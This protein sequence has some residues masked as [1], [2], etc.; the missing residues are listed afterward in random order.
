LTIDRSMCRVSIVL[1]AHNAGETLLRAAGSCLA[2][3]FDDLE[4]VI[5]D[6]A[7]GDDTPWLISELC[8]GDDRV[9]GI[10]LEGHGGVAVAA[11]AGRRAARGEFVARMDADDFSHPERIGKQVAY[12]DGNPDVAGCGTGVKLVGAPAADPGRGFGAHVRWLNSL[13]APGRM[14]AER[15]V[16]S[17]IANPSSMVRAES[18]D[19]VGGHRDTDWA[20]DYDLWLRMFDKGLGLANVGEVLLDW[21]DSPG[22]LTRS[23]DRYSAANFSRAKAHY[24][25][26]LPQVASAGV[27]IAGAGPIG[28]RLARDLIAEGVRVH[29]FYEVNPRRVGQRIGDVPVEGYASLDLRDS[30]LLGSVGLPGARGQIR[31]LARA[32]GFREGCDFFPVA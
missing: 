14:A 4:L 8:R 17:P 5:V 19:A 28:K 11:E 1:P 25:A 10:Q 20:E 29:R 32:A 26:K 15:F 3:T 24:I 16:D 18:L 27:E 31:G 12:L 9:R 21:H 22:R 7:S 6:D 30:V 2:Q 13:G 23:D